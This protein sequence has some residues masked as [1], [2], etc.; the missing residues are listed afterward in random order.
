MTDPSDSRSPSQGMGARLAGFIAR[1]PG[2]IVVIALLI[3][4]LGFQ[5]ARRLAINQELRA[6][7]PDHASS[8]VRLDAA[9]AR[10][11]NQSDLYVS[12]RSP[13]R[14]AN[15]AFGE[16]IAA[17]LSARDDIRYVLFHRDPTFFKEHA[18]LYA[19][20]GDLLEIR[21]RVIEK[22]QAQIRRE[23]SAFGDD[24][25]DGPADAGVD[26]INLDEKELRRRY[27]LE[28]EPPEYFEADGGQLIVVRAR[29]TRPNTDISYARGL[30][31]DVQASITATDPAAHHPEMQV[32]IN[33]SYA[34]HT[35]LATQL[36]N[37]I[38]NGSL[39]A[40]ALLLLV[41]AAYFR[42]LRAVPL[43][44]TPL[45]ISAFTALAFATW[46]YGYLN[47]VSAFIF[48][49]QLGLG[50]DF[51]TH[52]LSR[53]RDELARGLA[54][55]EA[56][57]TAIT[58]T[59]VST[60]GGALST[61]FSFLLLVLAEFRGFTQFGLVAF[62]GIL[63]AYVAA[64]V[65]L[66]ALV[67]LFDRVWPWKV[68]RKP[69]AG[70][71][72]RADPRP[73]PVLA[74]VAL[75]GCLALGAAGAATLPD[76]GFEYDL[77]KLG[78]PS[79]ATPEEKAR[80]VQFR[81]AVGKIQASDP[82]IALTDGLDQTRDLH[83]QLQAIHELRHDEIA[84]I[85]GLPP[86]TPDATPPPPPKPAPKPK[87]ADEE[88][89][90]E[91]FEAEP[92][93]PKFVALA[94]LAEAH[95]LVAPETRKQLEAY[96]PERLREMDDLLASVLSIY[97]FI[98]ELQ[99]EKL[100][101]IRDIRERIEKK[102][103]ALSAA[104]AEKLKTWERY[105]QVDRPVTV[106]D[107]PAWVRVQFTDMDGQLGRFVAFW[108]N[109]E[110]ADYVQARRI[111][112]NS[113]TLDTAAG[114][115]PAVANYYVIPEIVETIRG[116]GPLVMSAVFGVLI[117]TALLM[118][119]SLAQMLLV[120]LTVGL[121]L[122]WLAGLFAALDWKLNLF[123]LIALPLLVGMGQDDSL[124][125]IHRYREEGPG[126]L[127]FVLRETGGAVFL[128]TLTTV[129]GFS[130]MLFVQHQGLRSLGYTA[131]IGMTLCLVSSVIVIPS[132]LR[133]VEW[134]R[135]RRSGGPGIRP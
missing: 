32:E 117:V 21:A 82:T 59:G 17:S 108:H 115:V 80:S 22:I 99:D 27:H 112:A 7:L 34:F 134:M 100:L 19:K 74:F 96:G 56:I 55:R 88:E 95:A 118:F 13:S 86:L 53:Y 83:R 90:D 101:V 1:H 30:F 76:L 26:D 104:D 109:G 49:V 78:V 131:C 124:H 36:E 51:G 135:A 70:S 130:S 120:V 62:V 121:A 69:P 125:I 37:D 91:E 77:N 87:S 64:I 110:T 61:A 114:P 23:M 9:S 128:T 25:Q 123:N 14:A 33:G 85:T 48:A 103:G 24:Q 98:P 29:P 66:P 16:K 35:R 119:R 45:L 133:I 50:I 10:L 113:D 107:L 3:G 52:M 127:R 6:M 94:A 68:R 129:I 38:I 67:L 41:V 28:D 2:L 57:A 39:A 44:L 58:T 84:A 122:L 72:T 4:A 5:G 63:V 43:V 20:L 47:L 73:A 54:H 116:D 46:M 71:F 111:R 93:D 79:K 92:D 65:V 75:T 40:F 15:I 89:E 60:A 126:S 8:V 102:R 42:G 105:L 12:I 97:S 18:L 106:A 31:A 132:G 81:G 11:G